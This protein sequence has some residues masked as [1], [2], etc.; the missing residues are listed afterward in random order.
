MAKTAPPSPTHVAA[1]IAAGRGASLQKKPATVLIAK[2][3]PKPHVASSMALGRGSVGIQRV[4]FGQNGIPAAVRAAPTQEQLAEEKLRKQKADENQVKALAERKSQI[5]HALRADLIVYAA[6]H[7]GTT[8]SVLAD[9]AGAPLVRGYSGGW[10][11]DLGVQ[12]REVLGTVKRSRDVFNIAR[13]LHGTACAEPH[14]VYLYK[15]KKAQPGKPV[16][17]LAYD[18]VKGML[19]PACGNCAAILARYDIEDLY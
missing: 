7:P 8:V 11:A 16:Y 17:S 12:D 3:G 2:P 19:K 10:K 18:E 5:R 9:A 6:Q 4:W 14:C 1:A 13:G 15:E